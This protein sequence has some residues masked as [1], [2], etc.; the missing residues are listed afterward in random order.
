METNE[1][2]HYSVRAIVF[3]E[4]GPKAPKDLTRSFD[5][6][7]NYRSIVFS[8]D[9]ICGVLERRQGSVTIKIKRRDLLLHH[10][11]HDFA[12]FIVVM[13]QKRK[14]RHSLLLELAILPL[15][16]NVRSKALDKA[17]PAIVLNSHHIK[18]HE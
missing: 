8:R 4:G 7:T 14:R 6:R 15:V 16:K 10:Y 13:K 3:V 12:Q 18:W 2:G 11:V 1:F 5:I 17:R 9:N